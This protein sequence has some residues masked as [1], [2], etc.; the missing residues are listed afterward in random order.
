MP[1]YDELDFIALYSSQRCYHLSRVKRTNSIKLA[2]TGQNWLRDQFLPL[3]GCCG[4]IFTR[5]RA[6]FFVRTIK[7]NKT[8]HGHCT[9]SNLP[10]RRFGLLSQNKN[11]PISVMLTHKQQ[12][13]FRDKEWRRNKKVLK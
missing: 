9:P 5:F 8:E 11:T 4:C 7:N 2:N 12:K 3:N 10:L 1:K 6:P 13:T